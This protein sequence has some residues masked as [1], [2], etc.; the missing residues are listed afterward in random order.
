MTIQ[1][2]DLPTLDKRGKISQV[3]SASDDLKKLLWNCILNSKKV[4]PIKDILIDDI[5]S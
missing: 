3:I 2:N 1:T 5:Q 4:I